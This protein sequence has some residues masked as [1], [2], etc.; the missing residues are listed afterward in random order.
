[1]EPHPAAGFS[2]LLPAALHAV[3]ADAHIGPCR[4]DLFCIRNS[5]LTADGIIAGTGRWPASWR[6]RSFPR[7]LRRAG[8]GGSAGP[9]GRR[10][11]SREG[12]FPKTAAGTVAH[13]AAQVASAAVRAVLVVARAAWAAVRA[14]SA[15]ARAVLAAVRAVLAAV[16]AAWAAVR[17]ASAA[18]RMAFVV[19]RWNAAS[20]ERFGGG[21]GPARPAG[22]DDT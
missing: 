11:R 10:R 20:R 2:T 3:G 13:P 6:R 18:V 5:R 9:E 16:R 21:T 8:A 19:G 1:M 7:R 14:A 12:A 17:S 22:N 15:A 4:Y